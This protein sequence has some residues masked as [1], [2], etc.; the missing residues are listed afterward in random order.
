MAR[1]TNDLHTNDALWE[2]SARKLP[3]DDPVLRPH[4]EQ[5][6]PPEG[7]HQCDDYFDVIMRVR[8][9]GGSPRHAHRR[10]R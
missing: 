7:A 10:K 6:E 3:A 4:V 5:M 1:Y 2:S 9:C 8:Q